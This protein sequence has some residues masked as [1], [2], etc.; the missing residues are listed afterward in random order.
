MKSLPSEDPFDHTKMSFGEHLEEL[1][2]ALGKAL[3]AL[4]VGFLIGL[5]FAG[6]LIRFVQSP[7]EE[8]LRDLRVKQKL[9]RYSEAIEARRD[10][11]EPV[12][13]MSDEQMRDYADHG[14]LPD[15][16]RVELQELVEALKR[17]GIDVPT[18]PA[19]DAGPVFVPFAL[20]KPIKDDPGMRTIGTGAPDAFTVYVK[21]ALV[22]GAV[23][24]SPAIFYFLW[25]FV[26]AGL[27]PHER[28]YIHVFMPMSIVLFLL[29]AAVAFFLVFRYVLEFLFYFYDVM[30]IDPTLRISEWLSFVL[31]LPVGFGVS[32]QM[33][34]VML[35]LDRVGIVSPGFYLR[36][37]RLAVLIIAVLSM[38]L[39][40]ADPWSMLILAGFLTPLYFG[41]ILLC[42]YLPAF[43]RRSE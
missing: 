23:I 43:G 21:A 6:P 9:R 14:L 1:R 42:K 11:G 22:I 16:G 24:S 15:S 35:F 29:G 27:F 30:D 40:P 28:R 2:S 19:A 26:A 33:P 3:L 8:G 18:P 5:V 39:T 37:W 41:G 7:L 32:F 34:L 12:P 36:H 13:E 25:S 38:M 31:I 17:L 20:W 10:A 4:I